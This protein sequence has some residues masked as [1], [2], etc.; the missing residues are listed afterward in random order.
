MQVIECSELI[1]CYICYT[2]ETSSFHVQRQFGAQPWHQTARQD[3]PLWRLRG[4]RMELRSG[5]SVFTT[6]PLTHLTRFHVRSKG[7]P[8]HIAL[9]LNPAVTVSALSI[10]FQGGFAGKDCTIALE[11]ADGRPLHS[12]SFYPDD[13]NAKQLFQ[14][15]APV[16]QVSKVRVLFKG[17][18]DFF[19]RIIVYG[20]E[21][22]WWIH[23]KWAFC[24]CTQIV[25]INQSKIIYGE[26]LCLARCSRRRFIIEVA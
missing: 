15:Q 20:F 4:H 22:F 7:T 21:L 26:R 19:G 13:I 23:D 18:T 10:Q 14:L 17:S 11:A 6:L 2:D 8:Q 25:Y 16:E 9:L 5:I 3:V 1:Y 12:E 24:V